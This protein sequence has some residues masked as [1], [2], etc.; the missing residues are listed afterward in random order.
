MGVIVIWS[1]VLFNAHHV[2]LHYRDAVVPEP[3]PGHKWKLVQHDNKVCV[4]YGLYRVCVYETIVGYVCDNLEY[5]AICSSIH[6]LPS[7]YVYSDI[8]VCVSNTPM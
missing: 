3:P 8:V 1:C 2:R 7:V 4:V 6:A 5:S